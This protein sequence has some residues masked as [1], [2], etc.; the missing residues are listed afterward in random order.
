MTE[1]VQTREQ[2]LAD[3]VVA[4]V[5]SEQTEGNIVGEGMLRRQSKWF[6]SLRRCVQC[7][8]LEDPE[9]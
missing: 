9:K 2:L 5:Y 3:A 8:V 1:K 4:G 7:A 6:T